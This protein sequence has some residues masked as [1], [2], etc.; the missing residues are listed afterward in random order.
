MEIVLWAICDYFYA[1]RVY[2]DYLF[3]ILA[4]KHNALNF[5]CV[6]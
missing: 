6:F 4:F 5:H 2:L 1:K 3:L